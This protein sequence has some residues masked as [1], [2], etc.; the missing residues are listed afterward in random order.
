MKK[1]LAAALL[2][3]SI[4]AAPA[5]ALVVTSGS[6]NVN[7]GDT[8][9]ID[10]IFR[11][12]I[13]ST[14]AAPKAFPGEFGSGLL[15][16][17]TVSVS[18]APNALQDVFYKI[19]YEPAD[20]NVHASAYLNSYNPLSKGDNY[21]GDIGASAAGFFEVKVTAGGSLLLLFSQN[22]STAAT[23]YTYTVEAFSDV[24]GGQN[25]GAVPEP[26]TW[27][28]MI[29]GFALVGSAMRRRATAVSFA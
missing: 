7:D 29:G 1:L 28:M 12:G 2:G 20:A 14:W 27:A 25:F 6:G 18:F 24:N 8:S 15:Y 11:D 23:G 16:F 9:Q 21:L 22:S 10:R 13:A 19:S 26:A 17:D 5:Q 3:A 4:L